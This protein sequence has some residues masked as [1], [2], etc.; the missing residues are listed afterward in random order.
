MKR[1]IKERFRALAKQSKGLQRLSDNDLLDFSEQIDLAVETAS[2]ERTF[3][4]EDLSLL[5]TIN[6]ARNDAMNRRYRDINPNMPPLIERVSEYLNTD[7]SKRM[8]YPVTALSTYLEMKDRRY[9]TNLLIDEGDKI[10]VINAVGDGNCG[11]RAI[12]QS[13]LI[14]GVVK[15]GETQQFVFNYLEGLYDRQRETI[16]PNGKDL[17]GSSSKQN[18]QRDVDSF[19]NKYKQ[20]QPND[21]PQLI[22]DYFGVHGPEKAPNDPVLFTLA[23]CLRFDLDDHIQINNEGDSNIDRRTLGQEMDIMDWFGYLSA[24]GIALNIDGVGGQ[25]ETSVLKHLMPYRN[26]LNTLQ[27]SP[28]DTPQVNIE[29]YC[30]SGHFLS[31]FHT[32]TASVSNLSASVIDLP[33]VTEP[34]RSGSGVPLANARGSDRSGETMTEVNLSHPVQ[35]PLNDVYIHE[36]TEKYKKGFFQVKQEDKIKCT[37]IDKAEALKGESDEDFA[38]RLQEAE[39]RKAGYVGPKKN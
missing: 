22:N 34:G 20:M 32:R 35:A 5:Q 4:E 21:L 8:G 17:Y 33:D 36:L 6:S 7:I 2:R 19:L 3:D 10:G 29:V 13:L 14:Q 1:K 23:G 28:V 24:N 27:L 12:L 18:I 38:I 16:D 31:L 25:G 26:G 11:P 9:I 30:S 37:D 15:G 39:L